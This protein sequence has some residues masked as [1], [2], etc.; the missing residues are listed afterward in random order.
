VTRRSIM[1]YA[2]A[3]RPRHVKGSETEKGKMIDEFIQ[4]AGFHP[5]A[6]I[7]LLNGG[8]RSAS[9]KRRGRRRKHGTATQEAL[10]RVWEASDRLC[11]KRLR[12]FLPEMVRV[13][14]QHG[15]QRINASWEEQLCQMSP[16]TIDR[17]LRAYRGVGHGSHFLQP[18]REVCW[19]APY[20]SGRLRLKRG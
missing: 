6:A 1:E 15:E 19:R 17:P 3:V 10:N 4:V 7:R 20:L 9:G 11:S 18:S 5:K 14:R 2:R 16:S 12:S 8:S 13:L